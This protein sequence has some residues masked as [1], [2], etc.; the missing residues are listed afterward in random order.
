MSNRW[1]DDFVWAYPYL[2]SMLMSSEF[3]QREV[4]QT[5]QFCRPYLKQFRTAL[6]I[7]CDEFMF[8]GVL[9]KTLTPY[10]VGTF[11]IKLIK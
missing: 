2:I 1:I 3:K 8:A 10:T 6:D 9:E 11:E 7:G 5:Y 4:N